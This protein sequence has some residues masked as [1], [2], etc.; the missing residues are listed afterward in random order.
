MNKS[1]TSSTQD[2]H[3]SGSTNNQIPDAAG[4]TRG[5]PEQKEVWSIFS[6]YP[7][8]L[9]QCIG[10]N[11]KKLRLEAA[12]IALHDSVE[13]EVKER[14]AEEER[15]EQDTLII[16][17]D[18]ERLIRE[19]V[20]YGSGEIGETK[21]D[22]KSRTGKRR[23]KS[24]VTQPD[25]R[26]W[27]EDRQ[28]RNQAGPNTQAAVISKPKID[29]KIAQPDLRKWLNASKGDISKQKATE[30]QNTLESVVISDEESPAPIRKL[31]S[32]VSR[33][34]LREWLKVTP[35]KNIAIQQI[36]EI[37]TIS[38]EE[39]EATTVPDT[40]EPIVISDEERQA[41]TNNQRI[42]SK[43]SRPDLREW[44]SVEPTK[45]KR[46]NEVKS[47]GDADRENAYKDL[48]N[49]MNVGQPD[50]VLS[51]HYLQM[52]RRD[53]RSLAGRNYLND[54][55]IDEYFQLIRQKC[56]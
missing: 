36:E 52:K 46:A 1:K 9:S 16:D 24:V 31:K 20:E 50:D 8:T 43:V 2:Q 48:L 47:R 33:P 44:L 42:K 7:E 18:D 56:E 6:I 11:L 17:N 21:P 51:T 54:K 49:N 14:F 38:D 55:I 35:T 41:P 27:L 23:V 45:K 12:S 40:L 19:E 22:G 10:R 15:A 4:P 34:D 32:K 13:L 37:V 53:Y 39:D 26:E 3:H 29:S 5:A 30:V 28:K 25:I